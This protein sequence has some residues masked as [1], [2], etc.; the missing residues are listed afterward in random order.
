VNGLEHV[1]VVEPIPGAVR[2]ALLAQRREMGELV[3]VE[4]GL[5]ELGDLHI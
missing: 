2:H 4:T 5:E 3:A 1:R